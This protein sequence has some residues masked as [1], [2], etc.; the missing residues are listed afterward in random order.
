MVAVIPVIIL[1]AVLAAIFLRD[2]FR[3]PVAPWQAMAA[4][5]ALALLFGQISPAD[6]FFAIDWEVMLFL[7]GML[8]LA[9]FLQESWYLEHLGYKVLHRFKRPFFIL[10]AIVL[11]IG[12]GSALLLNDTVAII[13]VPLCLVMA[14]RSKIRSAPLLVALA[15]AVTIGGV[16]SPIG[17]PQNFIIASQSAFADAFGA[18]IFYL[19]LPTLLS[20]M[21]LAC[22]LW[23]AFPELCRLKRFEA[24]VHVRTPTYYAA[25]RGL[26]VVIALSFLRL[27]APAVP[28]V[29][30]FPLYFIALAGAA[31]ALALSRQWKTL[32]KVDWETLVFFAGMFILMESVWLSG[33]FQQFLPQQEKL[34]EPGAILLSSLLLSQVI[35]NV[36]FVMLYIKA[37]GASATPVS[38]ALLA[39]GSTL[40]GGLTLMGAASNIIIQQTAEKRGERFPMAEFTLVGATSTVVSLALIYAWM[41]FVG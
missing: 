15:L 20:L 3:L 36:P 28:W 16:A 24:D 39:A 33:F 34:G 19:G 23:L 1:A 11:A 21:A 18:F 4:G 6:A 12:A 32:L 10:L 35:S 29:P 5:S 8:L 14:A 22:L 26:Q 27:L 13:G 30:L 9:L 40:A 2:F 41:A 38:L 31:V 37:L 25:R 7:Y 17:N